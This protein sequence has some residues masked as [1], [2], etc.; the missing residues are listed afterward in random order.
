VV[1]ADEFAMLEGEA[2]TLRRRGIGLWSIPFVAN[3]ILGTGATAMVVVPVTIIPAAV[4]P[5]A[6]IL[7]TVL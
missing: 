3:G 2:T 5:T 7:V 1:I 4:T 6:I